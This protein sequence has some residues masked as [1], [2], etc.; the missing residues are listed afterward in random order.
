VLADVSGNDPDV[1]YRLGVAH[2]LG[3]RTFLVAEAPQDCRI[4]FGALN[5]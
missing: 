5:Q 3:K 1:L 4:E 2:A